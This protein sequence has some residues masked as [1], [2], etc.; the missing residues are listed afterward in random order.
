EKDIVYRK[1]LEELEK[2]HPEFKFIP[3]LSRAD[4]SWSG[5][6]GYVHAI[7]EEIFSDKR[8]ALFYLCG[9]SN[10]LKEA[11]ERLVAMGYDKKAIK[12]EEYD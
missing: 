9:W 1:E 12:F 2:E 10:M 6:K 5:R 8:P 11:R 4:D 3:T 7:Y